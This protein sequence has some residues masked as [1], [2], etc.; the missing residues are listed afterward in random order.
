MTGV[1]GPAGVLVDT[2]PGALVRR[3]ARGAPRVAGSPVLGARHDRHRERL[4]SAHLRAGRDVLLARARC[5]RRDRRRDGGGGAGGDLAATGEGRARSLPRGAVAA[6]L[7]VVVVLISAVV[8]LLNA[9][10]GGPLAL[11][12]LLGFVIGF[13]LLLRRTR[14]GPH[15]FAVGGNAETATS[16]A[17]PRRELNLGEDKCVPD[18][19]IRS[20]RIGSA[21]RPQPGSAA[22]QPRSV[23][24]PRCTRRP[25]QPR[26]GHPAAQ[27]RSAA[28]V[29]VI[30]NPP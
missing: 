5:A 24:R 4:R 3:H 30:R 26:C 6:R 12:V 22:P 25:P 2:V 9:D 23:A 17:Q 10:R 18:R 13:D 15:I 28:R 14:F 19:G 29:S 7:A 27:P 21:G 8:G 11:L 20:W 16:R 1:S